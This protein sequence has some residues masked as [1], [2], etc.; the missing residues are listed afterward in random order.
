VKLQTLHLNPKELTPKTV[1]ITLD[2]Q[3][4]NAQLVIQETGVSVEFDEPVSIVAGH[5]LTV[6]LR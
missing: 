5:K 3:K 2:G 4:L 1:D 6:T